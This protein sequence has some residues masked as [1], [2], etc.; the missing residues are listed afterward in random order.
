MSEGI[1]FRWWKFGGREFCFSSDLFAKQSGRHF[2]DIFGFLEHHQFF[3]EV[4]AWLLVDVWP[5]SPGK[6][7]PSSSFNLL[8][9]RLVVHRL[10]S[11]LFVHI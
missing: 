3:E 6:A 5:R 4:R 1:A 10:L 9:L 11:V 2:E 8:L 7:P